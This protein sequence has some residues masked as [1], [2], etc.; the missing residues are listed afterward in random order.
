MVA[1]RRIIPSAAAPTA[2]PTVAPTAAPTAP[3]TPLSPLGVLCSEAQPD[4]RGDRQC[5]RAGSPAGASYISITPGDLA[6][7][8]R[9]HNDAEVGIPSEKVCILAWMLHP[10]SSPGQAS[11]ELG[12]VITPGDA[13]EVR[14]ARVTLFL[15][16]KS[17]YL[18]VMAALFGVDLALFNDLDSEQLSDMLFGPN[19]AF[20]LAVRTLAST[21]EDVV[22]PLLSKMAAAADAVLEAISP[23]ISTVDLILVWRHMSADATL[24][25]E[26]FQVEAA[27]LEL[28]Q[29]HSN[30]FMSLTNLEG[31]G[32]DGTFDASDVADTML[33]SARRRRRSEASSNTCFQEDGTTSLSDDVTEAGFCEYVDTNE[34]A[35]TATCA[36]C[37]E[38]HWQY[39]DAN[40]AGK[41]S[42]KLVDCQATTQVAPDNRTWWERFPLNQKPVDGVCAPAKQAWYEE[43][44]SVAQWIFDGIAE[45]FS[46]YVGKNDAR[47]KL[48]FKLWGTFVLDWVPENESDGLDV[49]SKFVPEIHF[50]INSYAKRPRAPPPSPE[51]Q[52]GRANSIGGL[53]SW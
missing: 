17:E 44:G 23:T 47:F 34:T 10:S 33:A 26:Q 5:K 1:P 3:P 16:D 32:G 15:H 8:E 53:S 27:C 21:V 39:D 30:A 52:V 48:T 36:K 4:T 41:D 6:T 43:V 37:P 35:G 40:S 42:C 11:E 12:M 38:G 31:V 29:P 18:T 9:L 14:V 51:V 28:D 7:I 50:S 13:E 22:D 2:A 20:G 46:F 25:N 19:T 24:P 45:G 49:L